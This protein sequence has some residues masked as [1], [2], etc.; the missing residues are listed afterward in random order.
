MLAKKRNRTHHEVIQEVV[1]SSIQVAV[2]AASK[3]ELSRWNCDRFVE[4]EPQM[5]AAAVDPLSFDP[6]N[7]NPFSKRISMDLV[8]PGESLV[9]VRKPFQRTLVI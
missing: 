3:R 2:V 6:Y 9:V 5:L 7:T 1:D 4:Q 8:F